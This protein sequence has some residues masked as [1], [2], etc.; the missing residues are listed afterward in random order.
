MKIENKPCVTDVRG[1]SVAQIIG[2]AVM[3][4][5]GNIEMCGGTCMYYIEQLAAHYTLRCDPEKKSVTIFN[6]DSRIRVF[7]A[8]E[9]GVEVNYS[10]PCLCPTV[11]SIWS[12]DMMLDNVEETKL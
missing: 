8:G 5:M 11:S 10:F 4:M 12:I 9:K 7:P 2:M 3:D 6:D 1:L